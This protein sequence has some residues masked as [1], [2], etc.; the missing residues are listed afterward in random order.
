[1]HYDWQ[2]CIRCRLSILLLC[3][4]S[5]LVFVVCE[6]YFIYERQPVVVGHHLCLNFLIRIVQS[7]HVVYLGLLLLLL[8]S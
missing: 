3:D 7:V 6:V 4:T 5:S 8:G 1:M 2:V